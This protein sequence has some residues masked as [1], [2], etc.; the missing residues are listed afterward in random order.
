MGGDEEE[1]TGGSIGELDLCCPKCACPMSKVVKET[2]H[3]Y[4]ANGDNASGGRIRLLATRQ[5]RICRY[6]GNGFWVT[7]RKS[8]RKPLE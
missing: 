4:S 6:C 1:S 3:H 5:L 7:L 2:Q 8:I